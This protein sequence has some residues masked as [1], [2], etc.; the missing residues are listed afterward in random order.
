MFETALVEGSLE[1][2]GDMSDLDAI[3]TALA[4]QL[5]VDPSEIELGE[6]PGSNR[7]SALEISFRIY[8]EPQRMA[9]LSDAILSSSLVSSLASDLQSRNI[10]A[11]VTPTVTM[12]E[13]QKKR[14]GEEWV[15]EG[16]SYILKACSPGFLLVN[17]TIDM[18]ECKV[19]PEHSSPHSCFM[20]T[21]FVFAFTRRLV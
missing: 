18:Q 10:T 2:Q 16:G 20:M 14:E 6:L 4:L 7:R 21:C 12:L 13:V 15:M 5:G 11:A 19:C 1:I 3:I 9:S 17:T 8:A